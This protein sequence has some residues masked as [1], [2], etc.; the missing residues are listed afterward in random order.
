MFDPVLYPLPYLVTTPISC[1]SMTFCS[2]LRCLNNPMAIFHHH[3]QMGQ[4]CSCSILLQ[5]FVS[6]LEL[7]LSELQEL[8]DIMKSLLPL[9][10]SFLMFFFNHVTRTGSSNRLWILFAGGSLSQSHSFTVDSWSSTKSSLSPSN[11][12]SDSRSESY[13]MQIGLLS[14]SGTSG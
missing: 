10:C 12:L 9:I 2:D 11:S 5:T 7:S 1:K 13:P 6:S 3:L 4:D 8:F 14:L